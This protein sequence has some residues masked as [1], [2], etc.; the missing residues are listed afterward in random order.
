[1]ADSTADQIATLGKWV[2]TQSL[3]DTHDGDSTANLV[4]G[5][6]REIGDISVSVSR[7]GA[8]TYKE[9]LEKS[10]VQMPNR[11]TPYEVWADKQ[12]APAKK[13]RREGR[14]RG[15]WGAFSLNCSP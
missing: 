4:A 1:M 14:G 10:G 8:G 5:L 6:G 2:E 12:K 11:R 3:G 7:A 13:V 15:F 9:T